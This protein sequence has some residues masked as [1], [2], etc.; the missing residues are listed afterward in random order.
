M[1]LGTGN[2]SK[3]GRRRP[4][5]NVLPVTR[6]GEPRQPRL[7]APA[8]GKPGEAEA[9][10]R[11]AL[12]IFQALF[13]ENPDD[14]IVRD[15]VASSLGTWATRCARLAGPP[16]RRNAY[17]RAITL[18]KQPVQ[19]NPASAW[20]R[21]MLAS[22]MRRRG[23]ILRDLG[24]LALAAADARRSLALC[25]MPEPQSVEEVFETACCHAMLASLASARRDWGS[26]RPR[27]RT[28]RVNR[29]TGSRR[30]VAMGYRNGIALGSSRPW[31][32]SDR[33][34]TFSS[35]SGTWRCRPSPSL[36]AEFKNTFRRVGADHRLG[37]ILDHRAKQRESRSVRRP[38]RPSHRTTKRRYP[39]QPVLNLRLLLL[40]DTR[41]V[42]CRRSAP[43]RHASHGLVPPAGDVRGRSPHGP[44]LVPPTRACPHQSA[45]WQPL[46]TQ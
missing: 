31:M 29:W 33:A 43:S 24:D 1:P 22:A 27:H 16:R 19:Q 6:G 26:R 10:C 20:H 8:A 15:G 17:E 37:T 38:V 36:T 40:L 42:R 3:A 28:R 4:Q 34:T 11:T 39:D 2:R 45:A 12:E 35:S 13:D 14:T 21:Y 9:Q 32:R 46:P 41:R 18:L 30:A 5:K 25:D 44:R 7:C 23:M